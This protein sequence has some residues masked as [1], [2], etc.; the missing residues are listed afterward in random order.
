MPVRGKP[1]YWRTTLEPNCLPASVSYV[2]LLLVSQIPCWARTPSWLAPSPLHQS[3]ARTVPNSTAARL[4]WCWVSE[5][6]IPELYHCLF[7]QIWIIQK[8]CFHATSPVSAYNCLCSLLQTKMVQHIRK[9]H[10]EFAQLANTIHTPLT[11]AVISSAPAVISA[12]GTTAEA[13]VVRQTLW[14]LC[15][16]GGAIP[17]AY[18]GSQYINNK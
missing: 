7:V 11:T 16:H 9:K 14:E 1:T 2:Q 13:V 12:D 8:I 18:A 3:V 15:S 17:R 10:P 4:V 5:S 6:Y